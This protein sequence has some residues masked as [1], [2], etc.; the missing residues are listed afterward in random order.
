MPPAM[1]RSRPA[2]ILRKHPGTGSGPVSA[3]AAHRAERTGLVS[4]RPRVE[5]VLENQEPHKQDSSRNEDQSGC[6]SCLQAMLCHQRF[7]PGSAV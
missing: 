1:Q 6:H 7:S 5:S 3:F 2:R 4:R